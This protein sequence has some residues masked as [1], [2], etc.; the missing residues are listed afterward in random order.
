V[1]RLEDDDV[2][3][4]AAL[5]IFHANEISLNGPAVK[6][7]ENHLGRRKVNL[8]QE[9]LIGPEPTAGLNRPMNRKERRA[10]RS[11]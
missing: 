5:S 3:Q 1:R 7:I 6:I 2:L 4:D 8:Q 11:R 9:I 10:K